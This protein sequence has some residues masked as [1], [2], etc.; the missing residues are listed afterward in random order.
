M[1]TIG[2]FSRFAQVTPD[3]LRHYDQLGLFRPNHTDTNTGYRY[4]DIQQ[5]VELNR[6]LALKNLGLSLEQIQ[7]FVRDDASLDDI[8]TLLHEQRQKTQDAITEQ[9]QRLNAIEAHLQYLESFDSMPKYQ[10]IIKSTTSQTWLSIDKQMFPQYN[11]GTFFAKVYH[12]GQT[13]PEQAKGKCICAL[14]GTELNRE[15][16][17]MGFTLADDQLLDTADD[18][19]VPTVDGQRLQKRTLKGHEHVASVTFQGDMRELPYAYSQAG[20][21]VQNSGFEV[22]ENNYEIVHQLD[23]KP[24]GTDNIIEIQIPISLEA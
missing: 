3:L 23:T 14:Y 6:I 21:W 20:F 18:V 17:G 22:V 1:F 11:S 15:N 4:Y 12:A 13:L 5:V 10:T 9:T 7:Q 19:S 2:V 16:W 24:G 8:R